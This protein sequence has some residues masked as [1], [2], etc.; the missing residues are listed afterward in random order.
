MSQSFANTVS[1]L[2]AR[3]VLPSVNTDNVQDMMRRYNV[4]ELVARLLVAR[5]VPQDNVEAFLF[6]SLQRDFPDPLKLQGMKD[7]AAHIADDIIAGRCVGAFCDFD[8]DGST[9]AAI[10]TRFFKSCG[11]ELEIYIPDRHAEGYG[12]N[13]KGVETLKSRGAQHILFC[14]CGISAHT[15]IQSARNLDLHV[16]VLDHHEP[17]ETLPSANH[18]I[19]P[20]RHDDTSGYHMLAAC[21][22]AFLTCVAVN[23]VLRERNFF[24]QKNIPEPNLKFLLDL[25]ALGTVCDMVPLTGPN[26][27]LVRAGFQHMAKTENAGLRAL[28]D[29]AGL[30]KPP[31]IMDAGFSLGPRINAGSRVHKADLGAK[32]LACD[33]PEEAKNIAYLL[34]DCNNMRKSIQ[35]DMTREA[36][37]MV[38]RDELHRH[39]I[40]MVHHPDWHVGLNGLVAGQLKEKY[41][42]PACVIAF[43]P[44]PEKEML[45]G[46]G[47]GRSV[48][49]FNMAALFMAA[50]DKG[51]LV[52]GGGHAMAAGFTIEP[53]FIQQTYEF[54]IEQSQHIA[55][56]HNAQ[57][58]VY[59]D[60]LAS[61]NGMT[62]EF[63]RLLENNI[64][65]FGME[66]PE[67]YFVLPDVRIAHADIVGQD[68]V[69]VMLRVAEGGRQLKAI[70]FRAVDTALGEALLNRGH[71]RTLHLM[72]QFRVNEWNGSSS[73]E[74]HI[75]DLTYAA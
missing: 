46:R 26:R 24:I 14:D 35:A 18:V 36:V 17:T 69:R 31:T 49:G 45:E 63:V 4:P 23:R 8:V 53:D 74:F 52:K 58:D 9:S 30:K 38:E 68:H 44:S 20:K 3:W 34:N 2:Q 72:G 21:A 28:C 11:Q 41:K 43:A 66:N 6:P 25:V 22:V 29:V 40:I 5:N 59:V 73:V 60:A 65:P 56:G 27:L 13:I 62:P 67:P 32:L 7:A 33:D 10:L 61:L 71:D 50:K 57:N 47:S 64:G 55:A 42:K 12:P 1:V 51:L 54:F 37:M 39:P 75:S 70:A 19:N 16:T 48:K 15:V